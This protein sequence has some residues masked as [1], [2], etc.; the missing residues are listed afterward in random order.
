M[1]PRKL[2]VASDD[3]EFPED[4]GNIDETET[5]EPGMK[6][7]LSED[8]EGGMKERLSEDEEGGDERDQ[9][10]HGE[11][12]DDGD[13]SEDE[14]YIGSEDTENDTDSTDFSGSVD[15]DD[16]EFVEEEKKKAERKKKHQLKKQNIIKDDDDES[17]FVHT[18]K[19]SQ[20]SSPSAQEKKSSSQLEKK[21]SSQLEK[22]SSSHPEKKSSS[23]LEKKSSSHPEKNSSSHPEKKSSSQLEKKSASDE[24]RQGIFKAPTNEKTSASMD[25]E[26]TSVKSTSMNSTSVAA[27]VNHTRTIDLKREKRTPKPI[28]TGPVAGKSKKNSAMMKKLTKDLMIK[29]PDT[30]RSESRDFLSPSDEITNPLSQT[31]GVDTESVVINLTDEKEP[32]T[33][34]FPVHVVQSSNGSTIPYTTLQLLGP[35]ERGTVLSR[36]ILKCVENDDGTYREETFSAEKKWCKGF[37]KTH[38]LLPQAM[39][40]KMLL[41][42]N[43]KGRGSYVGDKKFETRWA[44]AFGEGVLADGTK[45]VPIMSDKMTMEL[46]TRQ[47]KNERKSGQLPSNPVVGHASS[48]KSPVETLSSVKQ[49]A[50][51]SLSST[52]KDASSLSKKHASVEK[53][54]SSLS[55][56]H[57]SVEKDAS[58]LSKKHTSV[59]KD[60]S[61]SPK[62]RMHTDHEDSENKRRKHDE[63]SNTASSMIKDEMVIDD[64]TVYETMHA[65]S[66]EPTIVDI[67][68]RFG[69]DKKYS[70]SIPIVINLNPV[71]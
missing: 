57:T 7:R 32:T 27:K 41:E 30:H 11:K 62:K 51:V 70:I 6:E 26:N 9:Q 46:Q 31:P 50:S 18:K 52:E 43:E 21:S 67:P 48:V 3:D 68:V 5:I 42:R 23:Q 60:R 44:V 66:G 12:S 54:A 38:P 69:K 15:T 39:Q 4:F 35:G 34:K 55:K 25:T 59:E 65:Q 47:I 40:G 8:E 10:L 37:I 14:E 64:E 24:K 1:Q 2:N 29:R 17:D 61:S 63:T 20:K 22:K 58:S 49:K 16:E 13:E 71:K 28:K 45:I 19:R 36:S 53:D 33:D 56:K